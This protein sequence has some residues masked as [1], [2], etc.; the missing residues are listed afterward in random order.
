M[1][2]SKIKISNLFG[3]KE[4]EL[5]GKS[6]EVS[7]NNGLGKTSILDSIRYALKNSSNRDYIVRNGETEGE[8]YIETD[9]GLTIDRKKRTNSS[10]YK[11]IKNNGAEVNSPE[12]FLKDIFTEMQ[13]NP[14]EFSQMTKQEQNRAILDLIEFDWDINWIKEKFGEIPEGV[15]YSQNILQVL[16]DI[17]AEN[18]VYYQKRQDIN[19]EKRN[20]L[21]FIEDISKDIP[22]NYN[23]EKWEKFDLTA[24]LK[25]LMQIKEDNSKIEEAK[26]FIKNYDNKVKGYEAEK[27]IAIAAEERNIQ[28][29]KENLQKSIERM[30]AEIK[31]N[32]E[33]LNNLSSTLQDKIKIANLN[34]EK[35]VSALDESISRAKE[36]AN[37]EPIDV[38]ELQK[39]CDLAETMKKHLNEYKR[40]IDMK[41]EIDTLDKMSENYTNKIELAR[42]LPAE[43]LKT[44]TIPVE[45]LTVKDGLA[46]VNGVPVANLSEGEKLM[47]C[48]DVT[49]S[50]ENNLKLILLDGVEKLSEE[51]RNKVYKKCKE[52]GL[53]FI[54][55]KTDNSNELIIREV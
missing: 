36:F 40:M 8:I 37:K 38:T 19:R 26:T 7:G 54:A 32:E 35:K 50:K 15:D 13:L 53:Q 27:Q 46:L 18:G 52:K 29:Q 1:K 24:K 48:V 42:N 6:V 25:E 2:I 3:I 16:N 10:D 45:G 43:I 55:T 44:A 34:Y 20:K 12:S 5:D 22:E 33:K 49:L 47:L 39:E 9:T 23:A 31:A 11:S 21:A 4:L 51:N 17:Q 41:E 28:I 30:K 14:V